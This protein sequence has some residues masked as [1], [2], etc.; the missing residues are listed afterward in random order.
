MYIYT[1]QNYTLKK[2]KKKHQRLNTYYLQLVCSYQPSGC[3]GLTPPK[4]KGE[5]AVQTPCLLQSSSQPGTI[6]AQRGEGIEVMDF[7]HLLFI[8][9]YILGRERRR[10][11]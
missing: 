6:P 1:Q 9:L 11:C 7:N 2:Q 8:H 3:P 10:F 4:C 5:D